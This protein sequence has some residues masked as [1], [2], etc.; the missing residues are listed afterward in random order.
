MSSDLELHLRELR[1]VD[2]HEH[3]MSETDWLNKGP[4]DVL[5]DLFYHYSQ[6]DL[7]SAGVP[8]DA[9]K[10]LVSGEG[11]LESRWAAIEPAWKAM[12]FTGYGEAVRLMAS[13]VYGIEEITPSSL[14]NAQPRLTK[15]RRPGERYRYLRDVC[16]YDHVQINQFIFPDRPDASDPAFFLY[17]VSWALPSNGNF[18]P[19][20][21]EPLGI[22]IRDMAS[23][24]R[25][26]EAYFAKHAPAAIAVKTQHAYD[27]T[28]KWEQRSDAD[29]E[30]A[31]AMVLK[32]GKDVAAGATALPGRLVPGAGWSRPSATTCRSRST[33]G[34]TTTT[35]SW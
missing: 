8:A 33:R 4:V 1:V 13:E 27:R 9:L 11:D 32:E 35:T 20:H 14:R 30:R 25:G 23:L 31:L 29:A 17:D 15:L 12:Q 7:F 21:F 2:T 22:E 34:T 3:L 19:S 5:A 24:K 28:L 10:R 18:P 16:K 6:K 26:I